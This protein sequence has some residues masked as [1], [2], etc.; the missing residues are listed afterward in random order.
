M[1]ENFSVF[2]LQIR[3]REARSIA[4]RHR[5]E[6]LLRLPCFSDSEMAERS[7]AKH[8]MDGIAAV[9]RHSEIRGA[10]AAI[11]AAQKQTLISP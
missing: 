1:G 6:C 2:E 11:G 4:S 8:V 5:P 10:V 7:G 9:R 3:R